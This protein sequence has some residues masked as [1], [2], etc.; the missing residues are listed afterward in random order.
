MIMA[1]DSA[2][3]TDSTADNGLTLAQKITT[4]TLKHQRSATLTIN[5]PKQEFNITSQIY[6][7]MKLNVHAVVQTNNTAPYNYQI[8]FSTADD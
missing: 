5:L 1:S 4:P 8:T 7:Q 2:L 6:T 3:P